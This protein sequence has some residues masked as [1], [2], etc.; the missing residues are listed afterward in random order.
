M[1]NFKLTSAPL[2]YTPNVIRFLTNMALT[3]R[4]GALRTVVAGWPELTQ[5]AYSNILDGNYTIEGDTVL[6]D[7]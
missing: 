3:D 5:A 4:A 2:I 1:K 6:V 7:G